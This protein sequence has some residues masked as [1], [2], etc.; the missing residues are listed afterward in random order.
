MGIA[1]P[2]AGR[3]DEPLL[4]I[5]RLE[6]VYPNG[7]TALKGVSFAVD[8]GRV[9]GLIGAN[10]AGKSSL[11][12]ILSGAAHASGGRIVWLGSPRDWRSP[13]DAM[14]AGIATIYQNIPLAGT[15]SVIENVFL[16]GRQPW[17]RSAVERARFLALVEEIGY[18]IDAHALVSTLPIG[19]RQMVSVLQAV[20]AD[21]RLLIMDEP[22]AS[23]SES[24]REIVFR[25]VRTLRRSRGTSVLFISHFLDEVLDLCEHVTVL[26]DGVI[27]LD[28]PR[29]EVSES[30]L[31]FAIVG[32]KDIATAGTRTPSKTPGRPLLEVEGLT[33][34]SGVDNLTMS[35]RPGEIVGL[36]GLL[37]SGRSEILHA[38]FGADRRAAGS[39]RVAGKR[40]ERSIASALT[41]GI[42][43]V[44]ED[45]NQQ[46]L[47]LDRSIRWNLT[48][49]ASQHLCG[50]RM[51]PVRRK[52]NDR[53]EEV[54]SAFSVKAAG[55]AA[56]VGHLSGGNAQKVA[57]GRALAPG[58]MVLLLDEPTAGVD[59]GAKAD[60]RRSI[61]RLA[62]SGA[63]VIVVM[64]DFEEL[65]A[66]CTRIVVVAGGRIVAERSPD[67]TSEH[68]LV[69]LSG[70]L[71]T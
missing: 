34:P 63:A 35:V 24:E 23:L 4:V 39:V 37:G 38:I 52:E 18:D 20:A 45:R 68:E 14:R 33:S 27:V 26:R 50:W 28:A 67:E 40:I 19:R 36:A 44:P 69:A 48:L 51:F 61:A 21:A 65:L 47:F 41:A 70:G 42:V 22:T 17:R 55:P 12:R 11:I 62:A 5:D 9:H 54:I 2:A 31:V 58:R 30:R 46:A 6:K 1:A 10:G 66:L 56:E 3:D 8:A 16:A 49:A 7:T 29:V 13:A 25:T 60:I 32:N 57:L 15:L 53:A 71:E 59:V 43:L 64:S